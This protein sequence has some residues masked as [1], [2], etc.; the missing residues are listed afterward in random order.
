MIQTQTDELSFSMSNLRFLV[1]KHSD[2]F[3]VSRPATPRKPNLASS[4][5]YTCA[6]ILSLRSIRTANHSPLAKKTCV[7]KHQHHT[8]S[9]QTG[10]F[11]VQTGF[12]DRRN[13]I[14][15]Q[16]NFS[17][18]TTFL[19]KIETKTSCSI[20]LN[21]IVHG[22]SFTDR[23]SRPS[24]SGRPGPTHQLYSI[25]TFCE[26]HPKNSEQPPSIE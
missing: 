2:E 22:P 17:P 23:E 6:T 25:L 1:Q 8:N 11:S 19:H 13:R 3:I 21:S 5:A 14:I 16:W 12:L 4:K 20:D 10:F 26:P 9:N 18:E 24:Y 15:L 7:S